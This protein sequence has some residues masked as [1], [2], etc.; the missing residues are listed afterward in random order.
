MRRKVDGARGR[1]SFGYSKTYSSHQPNGCAEV[2]QDA[3]DVVQREIEEFDMIAESIPRRL[4]RGN[5]DP[6][7]LPIMTRWGEMR[8]MAHTATNILDACCRDNCNRIMRYPMR[9]GGRHI[10]AFDCAFSVPKNF[11][12]LTKL[13][14]KCVSPR[15]RESRRLN[16]S[17][18]LTG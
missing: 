9:R 10:F 18:G 7:R 17:V 2:D 11:K 6:T 14:Q 15:I 3:L 4:N 8:A 12:P 13:P 16:F 1:Q 5:I